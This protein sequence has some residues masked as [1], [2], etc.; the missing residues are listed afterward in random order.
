MAFTLLDGILVA[1]VLISAMLGFLR[2]ISRETIGLACFALAMLIAYIYASQYGLFQ[3]VRP[4]FRY[5]V[6]GVFAGAAVLIFL[7]AAWAAHYTMPATISVPDQLLGLLFG[8]ARG[9]FLFVFAVAA[10]EWFIYAR[11]IPGWFKA[12]QSRELAMR[13]VKVWWPKELS[14][15]R[16][17]L[18]PLVVMGVAGLYLTLL[19]DLVAAVTRPYRV[20]HRAA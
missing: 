12:A 20:R 6:G 15:F 8:V 1:S 9:V 18:N 10:V 3:W 14:G 2:G 16:L 7:L 19:T 4:S 11:D 5:Q 13:Y 17:L